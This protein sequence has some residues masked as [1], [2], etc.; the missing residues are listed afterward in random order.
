[1]SWGCV[2]VSW[3]GNSQFIAMVF[4]SVF[5]L[6]SVAFCLFLVI[7]SYRAPGQYLV[8]TPAPEQHLVRPSPH[9]RILPKPIHYRSVNSLHQKC[10][11]MRNCEM[12][13][14]PIR[15]IYFITNTISTRKLLVTIS[16][17]F[18][19][20]CWQFIV[21]DPQQTNKKSPQNCGTGAADVLAIFFAGQL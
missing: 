11:Y 13:S 9:I 19:Y 20:N 18:C 4:I 8:T 14:C 1:M 15:K 5:L 6:I 16:S 12:G 21:V 3:D 2:L 7:S 17:H 10:L